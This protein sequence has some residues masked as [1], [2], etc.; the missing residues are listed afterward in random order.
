MSFASFSDVSPHLGVTFDNNFGILR[1]RFVLCLNSPENQSEPPEELRYSDEPPP[2]EN[3]QCRYFPQN[4][5]VRLV[6]VQHIRWKIF[7]RVLHGCYPEG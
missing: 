7:L 4:T 3:E 5:S 2:G 6:S 1:Q